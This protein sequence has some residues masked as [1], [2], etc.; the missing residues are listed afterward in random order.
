MNMRA[1]FVHPLGPIL[2]AL[3]TPE[4]FPRKISKVVL[5]HHLRK[6]AALA[7]YIPDKYATVIDQMSLV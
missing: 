3:A 4:C 1:I 7:E 6:G 5:A 2:L